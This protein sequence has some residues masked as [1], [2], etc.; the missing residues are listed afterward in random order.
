MPTLTAGKIVEVTAAQ[1]AYLGAGCGEAAHRIDDFCGYFG[2]DFRRTNE[3][4]ATR[5]KSELYLN[6]DDEQ[7]INNG[8][9]EIA[10]D[11]IVKAPISNTGDIVEYFPVSFKA[12]DARDVSTDIP[13]MQSIVDTGMPYWVY[14]LDGVAR[15][16]E[17]VNGVRMDIS[18]ARNVTMRRVNLT[19][20][21]ADFLSDWEIADG[22]DKVAFVR[23]HTVKA[24]GKEYVYPRLRV[25]W[26]KVPASYFY[27]AEPVPFDA[28]AR[29]P[30]PFV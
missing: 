5:R 25:N 12:G 6:G 10:F 14:L 7:R 21:L 19:K 8:R 28:N 27:D 4:D 16:V 2:V 3:Q 11:A 26:G 20:V 22:T 24:G 1:S 17:Y 15:N 29:L 13:L 23:K 18:P 9:G 30:N